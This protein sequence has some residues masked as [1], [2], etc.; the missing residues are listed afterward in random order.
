MSNV[1]PDFLTLTASG[2]YCAYG[3]FY[4]DPQVP[5]RC[6]LIS[7]AHGDHARPG[8]QL[9]YCT[10]ATQAIMQS[11]YGKKAAIEFE[12][13]N[14]NEVFYLKDIQITFISA[15]HIL[16]SA[17]ILLVYKGV[18]YLYTGDY[19]MQVDPTCEPIAYTHADVLITESTFASPLVKH[20][21]VVTEIKKLSQTPY[22][23]L[24]GTY[25]LG[26][27]QR[28]NH[29]I[30]MYCPEKIV[31][32]HYSILPIHKIYEQFGV[33]DL[34]YKPY[35]RKIMKHTDCGHIYMVPALTFNSYFKAK[36]LVKAFASGWEYL[37]RKNDISLYISDHVDWH[38]ILQYIE[39]VK[40]R[41]IWTLH[42]DGRAL[43]E[44]Y[45]GRIAVKIL[46]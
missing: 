45:H 8:N 21:D 42:G 12:Q 26:K 16:G 32:L 13:T 31:L 3:D 6:A 5:V 40:P 29:L 14:F 44:Y 2:L 24:L 28:L 41:E 46:N 19:K 7:H 38:D 33:N 36:N 22:N 43:Q 39:K 1:L 4:I 23:I 10:P 25:G 15:G 37:Q 18:R 27:A 9:V 35:D 30:N 11:R 34:L 17:Q 20:P